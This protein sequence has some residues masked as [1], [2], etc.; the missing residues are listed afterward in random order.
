MIDIV[1]VI[2]GPYAGDNSRDRLKMRRPGRPHQSLWG[3]YQTGQENPSRQGGHLSV[4]KY[5]TFTKDSQKTD[6]VKL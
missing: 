4:R 2:A 3:G 5:G 1:S 6:D